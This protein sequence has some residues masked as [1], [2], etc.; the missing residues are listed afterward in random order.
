MVSVALRCER[1]NPV[2]STWKDEYF[3]VDDAD[4]LPVDET[5]RGLLWRRISPWL[6]DPVQHLAKQGS[7]TCIKQQAAWSS[8]VV[9]DDHEMLLKWAQSQFAKGQN[10]A[11]TERIPRALALNRMEEVELPDMGLDR[12]QILSGIVRLHRD[13]AARVG[14]FDNTAGMG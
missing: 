1:Q 5:C 7:E 12:A 2:A 8:K 6:G 13:L 11:Q 10:V 14:K 9:G 3:L 4:L